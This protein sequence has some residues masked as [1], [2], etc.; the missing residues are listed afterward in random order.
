MN[1]EIAS[2]DGPTRS[3]VIRTKWMSHARGERVKLRFVDGMSVYAQT[4]SAVLG[5]EVR[6]T[7]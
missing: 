5:C 7:C 2:A 3:C 1:S 4:S 6:P